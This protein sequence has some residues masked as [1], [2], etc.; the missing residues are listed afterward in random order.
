MATS[1]PLNQSLP[2]LIGAVLVRITLDTTQN[3]PIYFAGNVNELGQLF[4]KLKKDF[5]D[6]G[7][8]P[9]LAEMHI[10]TAGAFPW[11]EDL[12]EALSILHSAGVIHYRAGEIVVWRTEDAEG[13]LR[14]ELM[15]GFGYDQALREKF[16]RLVD[17]FR[18]LILTPTE[19]RKRILRIH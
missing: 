16:E 3:Q 18:E 19:L 12:E 9:A 8:F 15:A 7:S 2:L 1:Q 5:G 6:D 13:M 11:S 17:R 14:E 4:Y 10:V